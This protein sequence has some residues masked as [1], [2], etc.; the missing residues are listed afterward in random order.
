MLG[1]A[2]KN[3]FSNNQRFFQFSLSSDSSLYIWEDSDL[4]MFPTFQTPSPSPYS[5]E[6]NLSQVS[7]QLPLEDSSK[8]ALSQSE[9]FQMIHSW[10]YL[11]GKFQRMRR[12]FGDVWKNVY[13]TELRMTPLEEHK[14]GLLEF[15]KEGE[16]LRV[17]DDIDELGEVFVEVCRKTASEVTLGVAGFAHVDAELPLSRSTTYYLNYDDDEDGDCASV[18]TENSVLPGYP[19][20][21][22]V[23]ELCEKIGELKVQ[24]VCIKTW[25]A[26]PR[27]VV[28]IRLVVTSLKRKMVHFKKLNGRHVVIQSCANEKEKMLAVISKVMKDEV[29]VKMRKKH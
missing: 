12:K 4:W 29:S 5:D 7:E 10:R 27:N 14:K 20:E 16:M 9:L 25:F 28:F 6:A 18:S 8:G 3:M 21:Q 15:V 26:V 19:L 13:L 2:T 11:G 17:S 22:N 24:D 1:L 23:D